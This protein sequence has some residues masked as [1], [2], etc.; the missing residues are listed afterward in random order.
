MGLNL[1]NELGH[2]KDHADGMRAVAEFWMRR[3]EELNRTIFALVSGAGGEVKVD[4][5]DLADL[6]EMELL[7][8]EQPWDYCVLFKVRR[9]NG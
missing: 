4:L 9:R 3:A 5:R 7:K 8:I 1:I 6:P 2:E